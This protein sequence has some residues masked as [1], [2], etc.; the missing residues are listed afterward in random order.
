ML[1]QKSSNPIIIR[2]Q[3]H[4]SVGMSHSCLRTLLRAGRSRGHTAYA[5]QADIE[6]KTAKGHKKESDHKWF[7]FKIELLSI[8]H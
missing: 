7:I 3:E 5:S 1:C 4:A 2:N 6:A 8:D